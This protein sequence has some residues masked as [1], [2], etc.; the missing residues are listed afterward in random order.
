MAGVGGQPE[1]GRFTSLPCLRS[2]VHY[3]S[4]LLYMPERPV[5]LLGRGLLDKLG[6]SIVFRQGEVQGGKASELRT[7]LLV[8]PMTYLLGASKYSPRS[9]RT[10]RP[11]SLGYFGARKA[12]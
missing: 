1:G 3:Y 7:H 9:Q 5:P 11:C 6:T 2:W 4:C 12:K 8:T 10:S